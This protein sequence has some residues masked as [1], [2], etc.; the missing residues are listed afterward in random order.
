MR[1]EAVN[2]A[3]WLMEEAA[4]GKKVAMVC[5]GDAGIYGWQA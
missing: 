3:A 5:S 2:A 1:Q 4:A